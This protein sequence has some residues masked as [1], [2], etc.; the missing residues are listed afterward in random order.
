MMIPIP[1]AGR[2]RD[3]EGVEA[4]RAVPEV[5]E[6]IVTAK[7]GQALV[8]LPEASSYLGFI[9]AR[10][11]SPERVTSALREAHERLSFRLDP[12]VPLAPAPYFA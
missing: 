2:Y 5:E 10:A 9:F 7:P 3:V 12:S 4:A 1:R 11:A 6:V 8:R